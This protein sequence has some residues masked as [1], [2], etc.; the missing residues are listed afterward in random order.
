[1]TFIRHFEGEPIKAVA[2]IA[3]GSITLGALLGYLPAAAAAVTIIYTILRIFET[4]TVKR[5]LKQR[6]VK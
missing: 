5:W 3:A 1:M 4:E 6:K 2:D